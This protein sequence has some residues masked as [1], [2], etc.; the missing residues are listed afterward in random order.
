[1]FRQFDKRRRAVSLRRGFA[2]AAAALMVA[3]TGVGVF[4]GAR[5]AAPTG[6]TGH[7]QT[8]AGNMQNLQQFG[9]SGDG[10]PASSAQLYNPRAIGFG[11]NGDVYIAD[12]LNQRIRKIDGG[13][14][15]NTFA[16]SGPPDSGGT[17][18][19]G[20]TPTGANGDGGP[21]TQAVFNQPHGVGV[22]SKGN[23]Y[24][25][26]SSNHRLRKVDAGSGTI[27]TIAGTGDPKAPACPDRGQTCPRPVPGSS[28][29]SRC[30]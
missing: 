8:V 19:N 9:Y 23:V 30:S 2:T 25:A 12:A 15:I 26:D 22:D 18:Q 20:A 7:I 28:S 1:M 6:Q 17:L 14:V 13:G 21:A 4:T 16:G 3:G 11:P 24:I 27:T 29:R 5:A 10:G